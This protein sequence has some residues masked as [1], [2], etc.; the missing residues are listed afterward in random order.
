M[1]CAC[2]TGI[3]RFFLLFYISVAS[4]FHCKRVVSIQMTL[5]EHSVDLSILELMAL[6]AAATVVYLILFP[7]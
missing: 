5:R 6:S 7:D 2:D 3:P 4:A 1:F